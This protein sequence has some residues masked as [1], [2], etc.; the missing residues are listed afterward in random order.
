MSAGNSTEALHHD[1]DFKQ[2]ELSHNISDSVISD[3]KLPKKRKPGRVK[4]P[5]KSRE[6][7]GRPTILDIDTKNQQQESDINANN[8]Q[9]IKGRH[10]LL[11]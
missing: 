11:R 10:H 5:H 8:Q 9:S 7:L 6:S 1:G 3:K 2:K 4:G